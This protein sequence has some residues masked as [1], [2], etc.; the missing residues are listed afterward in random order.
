MDKNQQKL[1]YINPL[2]IS[3]K[4]NFNSRRD[5]GDI[6]ELAKQIANEGVINPIHVQEIPE[7]NGKYFLV[8]GERRYRAVMYNIEHGININSIP[9]I[10]VKDIDEKELYKI[11]ILTNEGKNFNEYEYALAYQ[12]LIYK[13]GM[14]LQEVSEFVGKKLWHVNVC[15]A[16]LKRDKKVQD[17]L[18]EERITGSDVRRIYQAHKNDEQ[19]LNV[20]LRL[21]Q[22]ADE[23]G[24]HKIHLKNLKKVKEVRLDNNAFDKTTIAMDTTAIKNGLYRLMT[25]VE[26]LTPEQKKKFSIKYIVEQLKEGKLIDEILELNNIKKKAE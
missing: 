20:I 13:T 21:K 2:N 14:S 25:Y 23:H 5:F 6:E 26:Q 24:E 12:K 11:Q 19:A 15:L 3:V 8:D 7:Q 18:K 10:Q 1:I 17:L 9:A 16:H 22:Y 4:P